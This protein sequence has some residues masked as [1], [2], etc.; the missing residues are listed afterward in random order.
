[1]SPVDAIGSN[2]LSPPVLCFALG[3]GS[4]LARAELSI[5]GE[6]G[7][8][9]SIY[10]MLA[11]GLKG[12]A[13]VA[14]SPVELS[15]VLTLLFGVILSFGMPIVAFLALRATAGLDRMNAAAVAAHY[16]SISVVTFVTATSLLEAEGIEFEPFLVGAVALM[17][18]PAIISGILLARGGSSRGLP[19]ALVREVFLNASV[20]LLVGGFA[21][22][23]LAGPTGF[24][25][26]A[27]FFQAPFAGV[28]CLFLLDMGLVAAARLR[29]A[30]VLRLPL[31]AF[32]VYMP[33]VGASLGLGFAQLAGLGVGGSALLAT[34]AAS[35]S[36]IAVPAAM[37]LAV[38][39]ANPAVY[40]TLSLALTFPFNISVG[41][42]LYLSIATWLGA[43]P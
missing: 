14:G 7:K 28:L 17:E 13:A 2:L 41:I 11:I 5:P 31:V 8:A 26:V 12:G 20:V 1:M 23:L 21:V 10:L 34:L 37:R 24:A 25:K 6:V 33:L 27:P 40:L 3:L 19:K 38:P 9:I 35:A 18:T 30:R 22:G 15:M 43:R 39:K 16:G 32:S 4:G 42:P 29:G 36:Y